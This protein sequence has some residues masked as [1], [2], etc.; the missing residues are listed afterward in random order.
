MNN[1]YFDN[2]ATS[3]PKA[4]GLGAAVADFIEHS[5][6]NVNRGAY[7]A[8]YQ[9]E[10]YIYE[11]RKLIAKFFDCCDRPEKYAKRVIFTPGITYS[12]NYFLN[13][14]LHKGDSI[15]ISSMEHHAV[16]R[17]LTELKKDGINFKVAPADINGA[18]TANA[19]EELIDGNTRAIL[20][21]HA[22]NV[23]GTVLPIKEIGEICRRHDII[24]AVDTA[25][26]AGGRFISM[27]ENNI[28]FLAFAGHKGLLGPQGIGG[29][30]ISERLDGRLSPVILGGT[31][32][33]SHSYELPEFLP[34][35]FESGTLNLPAIYGLNH[36]VSYINNIGIENIQKKETDLT[37]YFLE[38]IKAFRKIEVIGKKDTCD[39]TAVISLNFPDR[40]NAEIAYRLSN[41]Y[42]IMCRVG[43]HCAPIAHETLGTLS[44]GTVRLSFGF[45]N[46]FDE[47]DTLFT[48]FADIIGI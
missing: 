1:I 29:F 27:R 14:F 24:F 47:I 36:S 46:T 45:F 22:S 23:C 44:S 34:D 15:I 10:G 3:F 6:V 32:S 33:L 18:I 12:L 39:R 28:D 25:Q 7:K 13:G 8:A 37:A 26:T 4:P 38:K 19:F 2:A 16:T 41:E 5:A 43:L 42:G 35:R 20:V 48:A 17:P 40:D 21:T 31:G 30:I 9:S 11:T